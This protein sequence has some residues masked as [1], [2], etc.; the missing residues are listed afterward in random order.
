MDCESPEGGLNAD[1]NKEILAPDD[2]P[3]ENLIATAVKFLQNPKVMTSPLY[4]KK[5]FLEKK[6]L[7]QNEINIA[8][9]RSGVKEV[10][11][12]E[13]PHRESQ[14]S[15]LQPGLIGLNSQGTP[16]CYV[17]IPPKSGW[18]RARDVTVTT[19]VVASV[20]YAVYQLFQTYVRPIVFGKSM[21]EKRLER[22]QSQVRDIEK[23]VADSL[24]EMNK[25]LAGIQQA[26]TQQHSQFSLAGGEL[27][28]ISDLRADV[29]SLKG[30]LLNKNQFPPAPSTAPVLPSWQRAPQTL[31]SATVASPSYAEVVKTSQND[32]TSMEPT[33]VT[34]TAENQLSAATSHND[35]QTQSIQE[36]GESCLS[37][38]QDL[39]FSKLSDSNSSLS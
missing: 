33:E 30:L 25:T 20:S 21:E 35:Q 9:Q 24:A 18:A 7:T 28:G 1:G 5:A 19:V 39:S 14:I 37:D 4:Q 2:G 38:S 31:T 12:D 10:V 26:L 22:L 17:P 13:V 3:R 34:D 27:K 8:I 15:G 29:A 11:S 32:D 36:N 23:T 16:G 6:G